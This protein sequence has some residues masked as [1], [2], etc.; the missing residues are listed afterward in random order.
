MES[1]TKGPIKLKAVTFEGKNVTFTDAFFMFQERVNSRAQGR[2]QIRYIGGPEAIPTFEQIEAVKAGLV[3]IAYLPAAYYVPQMPE[4]D[5]I[6]LSDCT[7]WEERE[8]G[9]YDYLNNLHQKN[10]NVYYLGRFTNGVKFHLYLTKKIEKPDL[11]GMKIRVTP[12]YEPFVKALGGAPLTIAPGEVYT[13]LE[14]GVVDGYGW[15]SIKISDFGWHEVTKYVV[16]PGFYQAEV[17]MVV[18]LQTWKKLPKDMQDML[19]AITKEL[20][21]DA[22]DYYAKVTREERDF[23][24][25]R[26]IQVIRFDPEDEKKYLAKAYRVGWS[27]VI[28]KCPE[29]GARYKE[30]LKKS[31]SLN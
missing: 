27:H 15:A 17:G 21:R 20:E 26:G 28:D 30:L 8:S 2:L 9:A 18:N 16:D 31:A 6:K 22:S 10:L 25:S 3:D 5:A 13:A 14:R 12:I 29:T 19:V 23:I 7:P 24:L 11:K 1:G 4:A